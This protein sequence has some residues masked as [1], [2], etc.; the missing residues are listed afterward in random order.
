LL[1]LFGRNI[2]LVHVFNADFSSGLAT[3]ENLILIGSMY[4]R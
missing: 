1:L 4:R 3:Y 2:F